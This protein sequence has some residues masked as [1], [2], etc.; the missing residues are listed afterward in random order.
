MLL[1]ITPNYRAG[2]LVLLVVAVLGLQVA[3]SWHSAEH[4]HEE[5]EQHVVCTLCLAQYSV[6]VSTTSSALIAIC[7]LISLAKRVRIVRS[8]PLAPTFNTCCRGP[9][10]I[11]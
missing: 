4:L 3:A 8:K 6:A 11:F 10:A 1:R 7:C 2:L 5:D 9:P